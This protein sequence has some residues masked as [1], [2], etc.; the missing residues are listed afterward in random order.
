MGGSGLGSLTE[1]AES[2]LTI[3]FDIVRST[4]LYLGSWPCSQTIPWLHFECKMASAIDYRQTLRCNNFIGRKTRKG[5]AHRKMDPIRPVV[6]RWLPWRSTS[7][8]TFSNS[9]LREVAPHSS[10]NP[11]LPLFNAS[12]RLLDT[13]FIFFLRISL[14][15]FNHFPS[16]G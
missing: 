2:S 6:W 13:L 14:T 4:T 1:V 8:N 11:H 9:Q 10:H 16:S 15:F 5:S 7:T 12:G 3:A